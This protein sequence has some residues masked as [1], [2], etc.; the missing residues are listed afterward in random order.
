[1]SLPIHVI[2][3]SPAQSDSLEQFIA[4]LPKAE[5]HVHLEGCVDSDTLWELALRQHSPLLAAGRAALDVPYAGR[6]FPGF[7]EVFQTVCLHLQEPSD[8]EFITCAAL[9][10]LAAQNILYAEMLFSAGVVQRRGQD[11][12]AVFAAMEAGA[13]QAQQ[14]CGIR[15]RWIFDAVRHWGPE[16]AWPVV[17][18][19]ASLRDRGV[20]A[21]GLGGDEARGPAEWFREI[22]QYARN[23]GLRLH[24][25][26]GELAGPESV[27][28]ALNDLGA[29][30]IGHG[31]TA[32]R[33]PHLVHHLA[34]RQVPVEICLTSN[35]CTGGI[36]ELSEHPLRRYF[37]EGLHVSLHS[38]DPALFRTDLNREYL[39]AHRVFDFSADELRRL[40]MNSFEAAFLPEDEKRSYLAAFAQNPAACA[41]G[42]SP[43]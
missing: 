30:R 7:I 42:G 29:E 43:L 26:A 33:D 9:R 3:P 24:A 1:M 39:L 37:D 32:A 4:A 25:H 12:D 8:Y 35:R 16:L 20:V 34:E 15:V 14:E 22:F 2:S 5:L 41:E 28:S 11:L 21:F 23:A 36:A 10:R 13:Q 6:G 27:W 17:R 38:D 18:S 19:A 31:L 40:A